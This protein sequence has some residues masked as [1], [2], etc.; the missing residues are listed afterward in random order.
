MP[1]LPM[2]QLILNELIQAFSDQPKT[3]AER[4]EILGFSKA[5]LEGKISDDA[6]ALSVYGSSFLKFLHDN[7]SKLE[8]EQKGED[9]QKAQNDVNPF[10]GDQ[11]SIA[12]RLKA[13]DV[14]EKNLHEMFSPE[15]LNV[16]VN[17]EQFQAFILQNRDKFLNNLDKLLA[18]GG[19][20]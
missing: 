3:I 15:A 17:G 16:V 13:L 5:D 4:L 19:T 6:L 20:K 14:S 1:I 11:M 12:Q 2:K 10:D 7:A 9:S 18:A 8:S